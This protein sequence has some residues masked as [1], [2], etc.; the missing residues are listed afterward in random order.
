MTRDYPIGQ[1]IDPSHLHSSMHQQWLVLRWRT[2]AFC[3][4]PAG[5]ARLFNYSRKKGL[6]LPL[7]NSHFSELERCVWSVLIYSIYYQLHIYPYS[8]CHQLHFSSVGAGDC[9]VS[10]VSV[11]LKNAGELTV[12]SWRTP[13]S[14]LTPLLRVWKLAFWHQESPVGDEE[15]APPMA[16]WPPCWA[17]AHS[18]Y[19]RKKGALVVH[20]SSRRHQLL[21]PLCCAMFSTVSS[22]S[23]PWV[24][25]VSPVPLQSSSTWYLLLLE[26]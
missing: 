6:P 19:E 17:L 10:I 26:W 4:T 24:P 2:D 21:Y 5:E 3:S 12:K 11:N 8:M 1:G 14:C 22:W 20:V 18:S 15:L 7:N 9:D 25:L 23:W 13:D 16:S